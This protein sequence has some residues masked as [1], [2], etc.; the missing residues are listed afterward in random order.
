MYIPVLQRVFSTAPL[1]LNEWLVMAAFSPLLLVAD[2]IRKYVLRRTT[3]VQ[4]GSSARVPTAVSTDVK[5][6]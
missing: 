1:T 2:E 5:V 6:G 3:P 4:T